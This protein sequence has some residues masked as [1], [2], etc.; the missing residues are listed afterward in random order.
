MDWKKELDALVRETAALVER[1]AASHQAP[2]DRLEA[3]M[4]PP[5]IV[6]EETPPRQR[7]RSVGTPPSG[8]TSPS[9]FK[10]SGLIRNACGASAKTTIPAQCSGLAILLRGVYGQRLAPDQVGLRECQQNAIARGYLG[11]RV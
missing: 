7:V 4:V 10:T 5:K 11:F 3:A 1:T 9:G 8:S 6:L 2:V